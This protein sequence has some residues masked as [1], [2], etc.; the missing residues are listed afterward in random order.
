VGIRVVC[1]TID[2]AY[3]LLHRERDLRNRFTLDHD[4][5]ITL[6]LARTALSRPIWAADF[7]LGSRDS[8]TFKMEA[9]RDFALRLSRI[10][11]PSWD[12]LRWLREHWDG[13]LVVK[14]VMRGDEIAR[15]I[16][17]GVDGVVVSNH[18]GRNIDCVRPSIEV[19]PEVVDAASDTIEV[20][21]DGGVRRGTD[22]VKALAL[23]ARAVMI[24]RPYVW[25]LA[26]GGEPGVAAVLDFFRHDIERALALVGCATP[27]EVDGAIV[28]TGP[29]SEHG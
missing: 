11:L 2:T 10:E 23:G 14:G 15:M 19:L 4:Q 5:R 27:A 18:G 1:L 21:L 20:Y 13:Q 26:A 28:T 17:A 22:V 16:D 7:L 6:R 8:G 25:G 3:E 9:L 12:D 24:G 29:E